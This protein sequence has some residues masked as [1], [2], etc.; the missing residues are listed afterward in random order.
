MFPLFCF[1]SLASAAHKTLVLLGEDTDD[2]QFKTFFEDLKKYSSVVDTRILSDDKTDRI[3]LE[4]FGSRLYDTIVIIGSKRDAFGKDSEILTHF[5]DNGGNAIVF[6]TGAINSVQEFIA[7]HL[8]VH[9]EKKPVQDLYG[10]NDIVLRKLVAPETVVSGKIN[11]VTYNGGFLVISRPNDFQMPIMVGGLQ[12]I[13]IPTIRSFKKLYANQIV[14]IAA[15]QGRNGGRITFICSETFA[16]D[17]SL[18]SE[19]RVAEDLTKIPAEKSGNHD[20]LIQLL[21]W[22]IHYKSYNKIVSAT[23]YD[24]ATKEAPVQYTYNQSI[25]VVAEVST[26]NKGEFVPY[27]DELQAEIFMLG[28]FV[29]RHMKMVSPGKFEVTMNIPD[30]HGNYFIKVFTDKFGYYN[31]REEMAIAVRPLS[32]REK[33]HF[34]FAAKPYVASCL[35]IMIGAFLLTCHFLWHKPSN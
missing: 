24:P 15:F 26:A 28:T 9:I 5:L 3:I 34:L 20:L 4:R 33:E 18:N 23:H 19:V 14:P 17:S 30:K 12:H 6:G 31:A 29:R 22:T 13:G 21:E 27:T 10:N 32:I 8:G 1:A 11:P 16:H 35:S 2:L 25:T 7:R